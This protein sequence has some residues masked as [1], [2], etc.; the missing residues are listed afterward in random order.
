MKLQY[1][2]YAGDTEIGCMGITDDSDP[3]YVLDIVLPL[4]LCTLVHNVFDSDSLAAYCIDQEAYQSRKPDN[5]FRIWVH[6]HP[7]MS[8]EPSTV[9]ERTFSTIFGDYPWGVMCI[10]SKTQSTYARLLSKAKPFPLEMKL[11]VSVDWEA[12]PDFVDGDVD[13]AARQQSWFL[14]YKANVIEREY[15]PPAEAAGYYNKSYTG[16]GQREQF[17][18]PGEK[19]Y[20]RATSLTGYLPKKDSDLYEEFYLSNKESEY[21]AITQEEIEIGWEWWTMDLMDEFIG[22]QGREAAQKLRTLSA[23]HE[24]TQED[25]IAICKECEYDPLDSEFGVY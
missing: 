25:M 15:Q 4:Q 1:M 8:A 5:Y 16:P 19:G 9:D 24:I 18:L 6:T 7:N 3:L 13:A 22:P 2:L 20:E 14:E 12:L 17:L 23:I 21:T 11:P 10:I